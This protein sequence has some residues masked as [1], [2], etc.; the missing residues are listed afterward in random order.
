MFTNIT[1]VIVAYNSLHLISKM[2]ST[3]SMFDHMV[4]VDNSTNASM[5]V[6]SQLKKIFPQ[7]V[8]INSS[9]NL[10]YGAGNNLG[11]NYVKTEYALILN[12]DLTIDKKN[13]NALFKTIKNY[14]KAMV[15]G[16]NIYDT[17]LG[18]F[19]RSY[20]WSWRY[21]SGND[22]LPDGDLSAMWLSGCC[23]LIRKSLFERIGRFDEN[24]FMYY[25]E[26]DICQ[27]AVAEGYDAILSKKSIAFHESQSSSLESFK[28]YFI[29]TVHWSR[30]KRIFAVK[31]GYENFG[32][33][34]KAWFFSYN[35]TLSVIFLLTLRLKRSIKYIA[36][37]LSIF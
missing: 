2:K 6:T 29:K 8:F 28:V 36:Q 3:L 5:R 16:A 27:R 21:T 35:L 23:L 26:F 17:R 4:I 22:L 1:P 32:F 24:I 9:K 18:K 11:L 10:G 20:D 30:S 25:E 34:K 33:I 14:P 31:H 19:E 7:G 13:L 37:S 15:V 12:P